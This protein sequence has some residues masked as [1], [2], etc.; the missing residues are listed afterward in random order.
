VALWAIPYLGNPERIG[1]RRVV[2]DDVAQ[3]SWHRLRSSQQDQSQG[4]PLARLRFD[5]SDKTVHRLLLVR[6]WLKLDAS[7]YQ[8]A[9][10]KKAYF[11]TLPTNGCDQL[12]PRGPA[13][14]R[15]QRGKTAVA[16]NPV[17][18]NG[19]GRPDSG[20]G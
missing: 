19:R 11:V 14:V 20:Y 8:L 3:T 4:I 2:G 15:R 1:I 6:Y 17:I 9:D 13:L 5:F 10:E 16:G 7:E 12:L 18:S